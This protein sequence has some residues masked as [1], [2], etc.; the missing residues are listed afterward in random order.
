MFQRLEKYKSWS[1]ER[2]IYRIEA[3][4]RHVYSLEKALRPPAIEESGV[5]YMDKEKEELIQQLL[6]RERLVKELSHPFAN[7]A[8]ER[9]IRHVVV[10]RKV[11]QCF[12]TIHGA[13]AYAMWHS[14]VDTFRKQNINVYQASALS[15]Y[16]NFLTG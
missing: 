14:L 3:L 1:P 10:H 9:A 12:R 2:L 13:Q 8:T 15:Q 6:Q 5:V 16:P 4:E 11:I 7:N